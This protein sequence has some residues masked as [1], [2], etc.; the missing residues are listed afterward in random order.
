M[1]NVAGVH[2]DFAYEGD[3]PPPK[4]KIANSKMEYYWIFGSESCWII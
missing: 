3:P 2:T 1:S 4:K